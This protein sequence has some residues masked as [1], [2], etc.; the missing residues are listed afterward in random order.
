VQDLNSLNWFGLYEVGVGLNV[1]L[2]LV[3]GRFVVV[4][5]GWCQ[6]AGVVLV[7]RWHWAGVESKAEVDAGIRIRA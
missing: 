1:V 6:G 7:D 5:N 3:A 2:D 4:Y